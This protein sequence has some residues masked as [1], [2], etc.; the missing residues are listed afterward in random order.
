MHTNLNLND[1]QMCEALKNTKGRRIR[2]S[3]T[4]HVI[5]FRFFPFC[6]KAKPDMMKP[7]RD[8]PGDAKL[9]AARSTNLL[10]QFQNSHL[11]AASSD[12]PAS[13]HPQAV[14]FPAAF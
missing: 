7:R 1:Y 12:P 6:H 9:A 4:S 10:G 11:G 8:E 5:W 2:R 14:R 13:L 3:F